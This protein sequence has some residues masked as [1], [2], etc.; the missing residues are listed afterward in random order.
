MPTYYCSECEEEFF[1]RARLAELSPCPNCSEDGTVS[2]AEEEPSVPEPPARSVNPVAEARA[3]A[4]GLLAEQA[5]IKPPVDVVAIAAALGLPIAYEGLGNVDGELREGRI[6]INKDHR[7]VRQRFSI[8]HEI[9][10]VRLHTSHGV[11][12]SQAEREANAF[13]GALLVP[14]LMLR[15][16][17]AETPEFDRLRQLFQV[18]RDVLSIAVDQARLT[19]KLS[20]S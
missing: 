15:A 6:R 10:H 11:R 17:V 5:I 8:A 4:A 19:A 1:D 2:L 18:S 13:A 3:A 16:A 12:G 9:G 14:P 20:G 7:L